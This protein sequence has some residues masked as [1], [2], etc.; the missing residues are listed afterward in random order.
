VYIADSGIACTTEDTVP[1]TLEFSLLKEGT[2]RNPTVRLHLSRFPIHCD[3]GCIYFTIAMI[4][5]VY[6]ELNIPHKPTGALYIAWTDS[7]LAKLQTLLKER[8]ERGDTRSCI[9]D[10]K[11]LLHRE[12]N[13]KRTAKGALFVT[14]EILV[15]P[16]LVCLAWAH[17]GLDNQGRITLAHEVVAIEWVRSHWKIGLRTMPIVH[18]RSS[19]PEEYAPIDGQVEARVV[20]N[21]GGLWADEVESLMR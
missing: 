8:Q 14:G 18:P 13:L 19:F 16:G 11:T 20:V 17:Q 15:E 2:A 10:Q 3:L 6:K 1:G 21:C 7:E 5:Q 12:P 9:I 4:V